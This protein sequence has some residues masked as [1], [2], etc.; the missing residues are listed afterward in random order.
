MKPMKRRKH[1]MELTMKAAI[2]QVMV[3]VSVM[4]ALL[5]IGEFL[6]A[7]SSCSRKF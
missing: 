7:K 5:L 4:G 1:F 6:R 3:D 2:W